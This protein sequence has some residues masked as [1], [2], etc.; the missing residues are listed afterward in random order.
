MRIDYDPIHNMYSDIDLSSNSEHILHNGRDC[1]VLHNNFDKITK[2][3]RVEKFVDSIQKIQSPA[4]IF[5]KRN[6]SISSCSRRL[7]LFYLVINE[8]LDELSDQYVYSPRVR[9]FFS[10]CVK[11]GI[12]PG[13]SAFGALHEID[14]HSGRCYAALF[15]ELI[16]TIRHLCSRRSFRNALQRHERNVLRRQAKAI[17]WEKEMFEWRSRHL[18]IFLSF[19]YQPEHRAQIT[20]ELIQTRKKSFLENRRMNTLLSGIDGYVW[21]LEE[22]DDTGLHLHILIA[23]TTESRRDIDIGN[24][25]GEYWNRVVTKGIGKFW[26]SNIGLDRRPFLHRIAVGQINHNDTAEREGLREHLSYLTK[27]DQ[28]LKR[29]RSPRS[30]TFG[31]SQPPKKMK[32][33]RPR[34]DR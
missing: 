32:I 7:S 10:A 22:G 34:I 17:T 12:E 8:V 29:K 13:M 31:M 18:F 14:L 30:R 28:Y 24:Q 5:S 21:K 3:A 11:L 23:Y 27:S 6:G 9:V 20:P 25:L 16:E 19:G 4:Y 1:T 33:G 26:N 2:L 15:N